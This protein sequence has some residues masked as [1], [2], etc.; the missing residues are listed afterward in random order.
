MEKKDC[1]M[2][3]GAVVGG[4]VLFFGY[5]IFTY[6]VFSLR[7]WG[8]VRALLFPT[9]F[10]ILAGGLVGRELGV[11]RHGVE[12]ESERAPGGELEAGD[13]EEE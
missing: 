4:A 5:F 2:I 13:C 11:A 1:Y 9:V 8:W 12:G 3:V 7:E 10:G 6:M